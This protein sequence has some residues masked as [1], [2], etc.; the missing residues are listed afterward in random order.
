[1]NVRQIMTI[2]L[3]SCPLTAGAQFVS[4]DWDS[5][6]PDSMLPVSTSVIELP[7]DYMSYRY[8]ASIEYPEYQKMSPE[9]VGRYSMESCAGELAEKPLV[10]CYVGVQA[11]RP[12]LD[13]VVRPVVMRG[14][15]FYRLNSYKLAIDKKPVAKRVAGTSTGERYVSSSVLATGKWVRISVRENGI[16]KITHSELKKMGFSNPANVR[17]FGYGGHMLPET[18]LENLP[19]D[20][21][22]MPLWRET[23]YVLFYANGV[24]DWK[25]NKDRFEHKRNVYSEYGCYFITE[26]SSPLD[27]P[28][29]EVMEGPQ[30]TL[31]TYPDFYVIDNDRK[32]H[33]QYGRVLVDDYDYSKGR[34][35]SYKI[36][37]TD[38]ADK[39]GVIDI[40]FATNG[41]AASRAAINAGGVSVGKLTVN[42]CS[43]GEVGKLVSGSFNVSGGITDNMVVK[44]TQET[45]NSSVN[46]FL[47]Y[48]ALNYT[49]R[50][51]LRGSQTIFR[52]NGTLGNS[53]FEIDGCNSSTRVWAISSGVPHQVKGVLSGSSYSFV[54]ASGHEDEYVVFDAAGKFPSVTFEGNVANQDLHAVKQADMV[55]IVPSNG[56]FK[57]PAERLAKAHRDIDGLTVEVVTAQQV[58]NEF[59]SGTPDVTA[60]RRFMKMLYDRA[61]SS[62]DAPRYLLMFGDSWYDNRLITISK[63][64]Q[65]DYLLC[66]ES[67]NSV[68]A[69]RSY[70]YEDYM[71]LLD[72]GEG[73]WHLHDKVDIGVGRFPVT[74]LVAANDVVDKT[75]AYMLNKEHGA[76]QN[77]ISILADDGDPKMPN[78]HMI[79]G[80]RIA[81]IMSDNFP[82]YIIDRIYWDNFPAENTASGLRYPEV[83]KA[84]KE[85]LEKGA[86]VVNYSGHGSANLLSHELT[87]KASDMADVKSPRLPFWVTAS[88]DI[89]PF[90]KGEN[91]VAEAA[92]L[93]PDGGAVGLFT[94]TRTVLQNYNSILNMEFTKQLFSPVNSGEVMAVGDAVR[95]AKC[96]V[97]ASA[98]DMSENKLQYVL[99][100]DPALRLKL[101]SNRVRIDKFNG[102]D[103]GIVT[104]VSAGSVLAVEGSVVNRDGAVIEDFTGTIHASLFDS[105]EEVNTRDNSGLGAFTYTAYETTLFSGSDS[106]RNGRFSITMPVPM[107]ISYK[108]DY[109]LLNLLAVDSACVRMAQGGFDN[110]VVGGTAADIDNDGKGPDITLYLNG[111]ET[112]SEGVDK[113]NSTPCL[114]VKL[115]DEN[116]INAL[117]AGIGHDIIAIVDNDPAHTYNL[118]SLYTPD[119]GSYKSGTITV[120]LNALSKGKHTLML[121][122]WDLYNNSSVA[123]AEFEV[124]PSLAPEL[125]GF[126][127]LSLPLVSGMP[128]EFVITHNRPQSEIEVVVELF[129]VQGQAIWRNSER[130]ICDGPEYHYSWNCSLP[131]G[132]YVARAYVVSD[133]G[134]SSPKHLKMVVINNK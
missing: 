127:A 105:A 33:C 102:V 31:T 96:N 70:V 132:I 59:S 50:L 108:D 11:K 122:A 117:G 58:Y 21:Q 82:S 74:S 52:G 4:V 36:P 40:S 23:G 77:V 79:D 24:I 6:R 25:F 128:A 53:T 45:N 131:T 56:L 126:K 48:L 49:R 97:I 60:Y 123:Y 110:F 2:L 28:S 35:A 9:E 115:H 71:G 133:E 15:S 91:S 121:R 107:D 98:A 13:V 106:V 111:T 47:D 29:M 112:G 18:G 37:I 7:S 20:L 51:V 130:V 39:A 1:M 65:E 16:H 32:S 76:W 67:I 93:N 125:S 55:I 27:F 22:E 61:A 64:K 57:S 99:L 103:A 129:S 43:S 19:D 69:V 72:D 12:Q 17:L 109:G 5:F 104:Q 10:E 54:G 73:Y 86:L 8:S 101:P 41:V 34:S 85:R 113:V 42:A 46:G 100:G 118:N 80:E 95:K 62:D 84:I 66:Y 81:K 89:G 120:P 134:T 63:A 90:D 38:V 30:R 14:G 44:I 75:I 87:W 119:N 124:V 68:N 78:Q 116:G 114:M 26:G 88:C 3:L 94:T 83:T 92:L